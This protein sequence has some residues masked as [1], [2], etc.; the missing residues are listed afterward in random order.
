MRPRFR[1]RW[2]AYVALALVVPLRAFGGGTASLGV[3]ASLGSCGLSGTAVYCNV[4]ASFN[5]V[6]DAQYYTAQIVRPDST[7]Q[8]FGAVASGGGG[9]GSTVSLP[10]TYTGAGTYTVTISAYGGP[11]DDKKLIQRDKAKTTTA[12]TQTTTTTTTTATTQTTPDTATTTPPDTTTAPDTSTVPD[13]SAPPPACPSNSTP[14]GT[15]TDAQ[16]A[17]GPP[18][19]T[20]Q[21]PTPPPSTDQTDTTT[22]P[23]N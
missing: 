12:P 6:P 22:S 1:L 11:K 17:T 15:S 21:C 9:G 14:A 5:H 23:Q 20:S 19:D 18:A 8:D 13:A 3:S 7:V 16:S 4:N 2:L 10:V